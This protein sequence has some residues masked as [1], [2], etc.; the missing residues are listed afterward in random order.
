MESFSFGELNRFLGREKMHS[1]R[2]IFHGEWKEPLGG[3]KVGF[4]EKVGLP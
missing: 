3:E 1:P 4:L 2:V